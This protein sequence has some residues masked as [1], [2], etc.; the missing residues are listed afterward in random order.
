MQD[1]VHAPLERIFDLLPR[2]QKRWPGS[3]VFSSK[4]EKQWT[5]LRIED[6]Y[7]FCL[8]AAQA[9]ILRNIL[10]GDRIGIISPN[11]PQW[12][13]A[14][15]GIL[16]AGAVSVPVYT[17]LSDAELKDIF[18]HSEVKIIFA[19]NAQLAIRLEKLKPQLPALREIICFQETPG[20][21][22]WQHFLD[23][24]KGSTLDETLN[25]INQARPED[26]ATLIY[27]S[28]TTGIPK[29]VPLTHL[30]LISNFTL[31]SPHMPVLPGHRALSFLPLCH[32]Y[33][34][35]CS[36]MYLHQGLSIWYAESLEKI[37][38]NLKEVQ[39]HIFTTVPRLLEKVYDKIILKGNQLSGIQKMLFNWSLRLG[40]AY[41]ME[42]K[43]GIGY[44][45][46]LWLARKLI[47]RKWQEALGGN[48]RAIVSGGAALQERLARIF[49]AAGI[50]VSEGYGLTET[51]PVIAVN[52]FTPDRFRFGTVGKIIEGCEVFILKEL[53]EH[54][55]GEIL[56]KGPNVMSGYYLEPALTREAIDENGW[57]HT[58]DIGYLD[59]DGF[60]RITDR[61][62]E[63][64]KT[65]G[66]K[67]ISPQQIENKLKESLYIQQAM[68]VGENQD[69]PSALIIPEIA[70][71]RLY[72][73][74]QEIHLEDPEQIHKHES[75]QHLIYSEIKKINKQLSPVEKIHH[76]L[77]LNTE[78]SHLTGELTPTQK[79][80]RKI[81]REKHAEEIRV[82]YEK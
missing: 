51:S 59:S 28:G 39:P 73:L 19:G 77:I 49:W 34:R 5:E 38:D 25:R 67:Y 15:F 7:T 47:F 74:E 4:I 1:H 8:Q 21:T 60:L 42:G 30:N 37:S 29:G 17:S 75:V 57:F 61:K 41:E 23:S 35:M 52:Y 3:T 12:L 13:M 11:S 69:H 81:I 22:L 27:T 72:L 54:T 65:S 36:Y 20:C 58:G 6:T 44:E 80:K 46:Q 16:M 56:V 48:V 64:F 43:N 62:K 24:G 40:H 26:T 33:E 2:F 9:L 53:P 63:I 79:L 66:G 71:I 10:P 32:I 45:L 70:N 82:L 68:V 31:N 14:D 50:K 18:H 76:F 78:W 55:Q